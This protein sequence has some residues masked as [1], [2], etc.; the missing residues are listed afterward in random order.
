MSTWNDILDIKEQLRRF[1]GTN[2]DWIGERIADLMDRSQ[3]FRG[4]PLSR[5]VRIA[6]M[7]STELFDQVLAQ[8]YDYADLHRIWLGR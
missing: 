7:R 2:L 6:S 8:V 3:L 1:D 4:S 5:K